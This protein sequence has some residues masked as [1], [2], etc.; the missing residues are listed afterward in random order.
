M[1]FLLFTILSLLIHTAFSADL[2]SLYKNLLKKEEQIR[3]DRMLGFI[4]KSVPQ[5]IDK[6]NPKIAEYETFKS[7]KSA[8]FFLDGRGNLHFRQ[9]KRLRLADVFQRRSRSGI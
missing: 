5:G 2:S 3:N 7:D 1:K 8:N 9:F 4:A 6:P